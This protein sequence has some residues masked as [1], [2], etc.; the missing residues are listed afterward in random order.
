MDLL[1]GSLNPEEGIGWVDKGMLRAEV[2]RERDGAWHVVIVRRH[3]QKERKPHKKKCR[4]VIGRHS[5]VT[6]P[7]S[8]GG[9]SFVT[10][11]WSLGRRSFVAGPSS[12][13]NLIS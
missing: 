1:R 11:P 8:R 5:F 2:V 7:L 4:K 12:P 13:M 9:R 6:R 3:K 10:Q